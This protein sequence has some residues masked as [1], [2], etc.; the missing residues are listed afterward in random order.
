MAKSIILI[1][2]D[3]KGN[4]ELLEKTLTK[5]YEVKVG[6]DGSSL[7]ERFDLGIFDGASVTRLRKQLKAHREK[8]ATLF[9]PILLVSSRQDIGI[10]TSQLWQ[11]IDEIIFSPIERKELFARVEVLIRAHNYSVELAALYANA[12]DNATQEERRRL[13]RELHDSVT[14]M[15]F[16]ASVLA[17]TVPQL[18]KKDPERAR[19]QLEEVAQLNR[20]ALS[21][22]QTL[23]LE[24]RPGNLTRMSLKELF[25]QLILAAQGRRNIDIACTI[26]GVS[27]LADEIHL[28]LYRIVQEALNNMVKHSD[29]SEGYIELKAKDGQLVLEIRDNGSGFDTTEQTSGLGIEGMRERAALIGAIL[30]VSS[31]KGSGTQ[32]VVS[33]PMPQALSIDN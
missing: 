12:K 3:Q 33:M 32:I 7:D 27:N 26:S 14:Q 24:M 30:T 18:Q 10:V 8:E 23:L 28:G 17:Q 4:R 20:S 19:Q 31:Q 22:M 11:Y 2:V 21:E 6:S 15:L 29:A 25:D 1:I 16:S 9:Q 13:A 5:Y